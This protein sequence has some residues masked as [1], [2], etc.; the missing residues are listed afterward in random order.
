MRPAQWI[1]AGAG[2]P[3]VPSPATGKGREAV[4]WPLIRVFAFGVRVVAFLSNVSRCPRTPNLTAAEL[5]NALS[6]VVVCLG[7]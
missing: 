1:L 7:H 5:M 4:L 3:V 2:V 6:D